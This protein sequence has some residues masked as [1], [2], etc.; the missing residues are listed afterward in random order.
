MLRRIKR[1][2]QSFFSIFTTNQKLK[3]MFTNAV[4]ITNEKDIMAIHGVV[5]NE[6]K[7][8]IEQA[9]PH[10]FKFD[11]T[12]WDNYFFNSDLPFVVGKGL[13]SEEDRY[14]SLIVKSGY[15]VKLKE[16]YV[17]TQVLTFIKK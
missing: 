8:Q 1:V 14:K 11:F 2:W 5:S 16:T 4:A 3:V 9:Y 15:E 10:L 12:H 13:V 6:L 17:G 7:A